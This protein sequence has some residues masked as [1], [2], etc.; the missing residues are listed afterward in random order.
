MNVLVSTERERDGQKRNTE[1]KTWNVA[2]L[3]RFITLL[4]AFFV[5]M[6]SISRVDGEEARVRRDSSARLRIGRRFRLQQ[7]RGIREMARFII[8]YQ[9]TLHSW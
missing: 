2:G 3:M 4:F 5:T 1:R 7:E 6:Y 9:K 8:P